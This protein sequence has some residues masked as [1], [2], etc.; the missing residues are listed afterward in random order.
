MRH[1]C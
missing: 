1:F